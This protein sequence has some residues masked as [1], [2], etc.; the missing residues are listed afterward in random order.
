FIWG[1]RGMNDRRRALFA[2]AFGLAAP[3]LALA[4]QAGK[5]HHVALMTIGSDPSTARTRWAPFF[6]AMRKLGY[7]EGRNLRITEAHG[8]G[9]HER[10]ADLVAQVIGANPDVIITSGRREIRALQQA[11][12]TIP[13]VMTLSYDPVADG[14][15]KSLA[16]PGG[17]ITGLT[18]LV[19][20]M[21]QKYVE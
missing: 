1:D 15:V 7:V 9:V 11:T 20:G 5:I 2:L 19:P 13:I 12:S 6:D 18:Y 14:F 3:R 17:N 8:K 10:L 16:H 21:P 4:Q